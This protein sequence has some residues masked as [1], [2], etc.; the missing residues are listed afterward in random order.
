MARRPMYRGFTLIELLVVIGIIAI[1]VAI[2]LPSL[3]A[4]QAQADRTKCL[5][6]IRQ[7]GMGIAIYVHDY[8]DLPPVQPLA[9]YRAQQIYAPVYYAQRRDGLLA[10][11]Q[12]AGF[13]RTYLACPDGWASGGQP[14]YYDGKGLGHDGAAYMD[15]AY[16]GHRYAPRDDYDV[17]FASFTYRRQEKGTKILVTDIVVDQSEANLRLINSVGLHSGNHG[18][19]HSGPLQRIQMTD[20]RGNRL[21]NAN[22]IRSSGSSVLFSDY[23]ARWVRVSKLTQQASGLCYP[24]PDQ[25]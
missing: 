21:A 2:L 18:S 13:E 6:N 11:R 15:Y 8:R 7:I 9:Q 12:T 16:W 23:S 24:P 22:L 25:W 4:A 19:S 20:G 17:R 14:T 3:S 5:N 1:L 10:L